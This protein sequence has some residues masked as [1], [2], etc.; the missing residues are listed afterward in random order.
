MVL[1]ENDDIKVMQIGTKA[2]NMMMED[3]NK[4]NVHSYG[5]W[6]I[7]FIESNKKLLKMLVLENLWLSPDLAEILVLMF[8]NKKLTENSGVSKISNLLHVIHLYLMPQL[9]ALY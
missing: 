3:T 4:K 5:M 6:S 9:K 2:T 8:F 7:F 1:T